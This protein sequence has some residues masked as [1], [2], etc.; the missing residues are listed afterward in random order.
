MD[1][2]EVAENVVRR[3]QAKKE[4]IFGKDVQ[5][6]KISTGR[7]PRAQRLKRNGAN[8]P[9]VPQARINLESSPIRLATSDFRPDSFHR[10]RSTSSLH[11]RLHDEK[12]DRDMRKRTLKKK[13][14][15]ESNTYIPNQN[16]SET[17]R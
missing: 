4:N 2:D 9:V 10:Y 16:D 8:S 12:V 3:W 15:D 11:Q 1:V 13:Y 14:V 5:A 17:K 7:K 6:A